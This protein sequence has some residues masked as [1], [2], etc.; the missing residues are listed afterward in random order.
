MIFTLW[1]RHIFV[2][3]YVYR[4][5]GIRPLISQS[6]D[7]ELVSQLVEELGI[8]PVRGSSSRGG[9]R[10]FLEMRNLVKNSGA[11]LAFPA[12]GPKGP[13][14]VVKGGAVLLAQKAGVAIVPMTWHGSR[15]KIFEKSWDRFM[16]PKPFSEIT[17]AY[18][19]PFFVPD[20]PAADQTSEELLESARRDLQER[21]VELERTIE[22]VY[23]QT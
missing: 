6:E 15:V 1:H 9:A 17:F 3:I 23:D 7:G 18:G 8:K 11:P 22:A 2:S 5:S 20:K 12:D 4:R 10:A 19:E 13:L 21:M 14:R 16:I